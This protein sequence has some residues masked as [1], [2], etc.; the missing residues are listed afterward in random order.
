MLT[1]VVSEYDRLDRVDDLETMREWA[2]LYAREN[3]RLR[4]RNAELLDQMAKVEGPEA[5]KQLALEIAKI[6]EQMDALR[7][8]LFGESSER[9][10][11]PG[12]KESKPKK[13]QRG[14][15]P[16]AQPKLK[17]K[18][19]ELRLEGEDKVCPSC[20]DSLQELGAQAEEVERITVVAREYVL[21]KL[22]ALKYRCRCGTGVHTAPLPPTHLK[23]GRYSLDFAIEVAVDKYVNHLPLDRQRKIMERA[24]LLVDTN[25]LWDQVDALAKH[26]VPTYEAIRQYI[27]GADVV[28]ADETTWRLMGTRKRSGSHKW[29]AWALTVPNAVWYKLAPSRGSDVAVEALEG[30]EG[31]L[32]VDGYK[33]YETLTKKVNGKGTRIRL[34][35]CWAH[36]RRKLVEAEPNYPTCSEALDLIQ[37]LFGL[38]RNV[39]DPT[40]LEGDAR[41]Q[42]ELCRLELRNNEAR[43]LLDKLKKWALNQQGLPNSQLR[44]AAEYMLRYWEGL[45][46][47]L[48]DPYVPLDNNASERALRGL[49]LGRKNHYGSRS[50]RG[51]EVAAILYTVL[52][53]ARLCGLDPIQF[54]NYA[55]S[56]HLATGQAAHPWSCSL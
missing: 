14:H 47:L 21:E 26:L 40:T 43:P 2:K 28:G 9:R 50:K 8:R 52:D 10:S 20:G 36:A 34:A 12:E 17:V 5:A 37:Q 29:W 55:V 18:Q 46:V 24:G 22:R 56:K 42:A 39:P 35:H 31:T 6:H 16:K 13:P 19:V 1:L 30:F 45:T 51:T 7:Q 15:G 4:I 49:V 38:E 44:R 48:E 23:G 3:E 53:T 11:Y 54:L 32:M 27:V 41:L 25:T 33:A